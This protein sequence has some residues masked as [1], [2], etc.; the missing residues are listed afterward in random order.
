MQGCFEAIHD[1]RHRYFKCRVVSKPR[2][3]N[4]VPLV[5]VCNEGWGREYDEWRPIIELTGRVNECETDEERQ[6][7]IVTLELDRI[8]VR[9]QESLTGLC[10]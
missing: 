9:I 2:N 8:R 7:D 10:R 4:V 3:I 6:Y 1:Q 5:K